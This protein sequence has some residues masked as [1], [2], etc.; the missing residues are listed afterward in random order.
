MHSLILLCAAD[1]ESELRQE[2]ATEFPGGEISSP[3]PLLFQVRPVA[4]SE[5]SI[6]SVAFARQCLVDAKPVEASSIREWSELIIKEL[7]GVLPE[8]QPWTLH[9]Q[10]HYG[11]SPRPRVGARA[12]HTAHR[13]GRTPSPSDRALRRSN[14]G[15]ATQP[16]P[17][18][19]AGRHRCDLIRETVCQHLR[20]KRR[21]LLRTLRGEPVPFTPADSLVQLLLTSPE[22]GFFSIAAGPLPFN[23]RH[24]ISPFPKGEIPVA[25]D[26]SAPS[27]AFAKLVEAELRLG[28][29]IQANE[30]CV[31][32]GAAPGSW[33]YVAA[34][35]GARVV[36]VDR[37]PLREDLSRNRR[38]VYHSGNAFE[39]VPKNR[40]DWLLCDVIAEP[41]R[42]ADLLENWLRNKWCRNFV[43]TLKT[44]DDSHPGFL[45]GVKQFL[46]ELAPGAMLVHL[47]ANKKEVCAMGAARSEG[48]DTPPAEK[49]GNPAQ[50][51][52]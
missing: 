26:K 11:A 23:E 9:V 18:G 6:P 28:R 21:S 15:T 8:N 12:W 31:D 35:R 4:A 5:H 38:I 50:T 41:E 25:Q 48:T 13:I 37:A 49:P 24:L 1:S 52:R 3:A 20:Q 42:I 19:D 44:R 33:T 14:G 7:L 2:L 40:V 17:D 10:P 51:G 47:C 32:L 43:V 22:S 30:T 45:S 29:A 46:R 34:R 39:F 27:R 36:A 16:T